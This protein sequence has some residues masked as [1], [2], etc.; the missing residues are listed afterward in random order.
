MSGRTA[1]PFPSVSL[2]GEG[3]EGRVAAVV[4]IPGAVKRFV[5]TPLAIAALFEIR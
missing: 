1:A 4:R 5:K 2:S 3:P